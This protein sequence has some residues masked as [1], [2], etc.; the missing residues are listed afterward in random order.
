NGD[1]LITMMRVARP[2]VDVAPT[3]LPDP[4]EPRLLVEAN[5]VKGQRPTFAVMIEGVDDD[6][7][8]RVGEDGPGFVDLDRNFMHEW[9]EHA[10]DAGPYQLCEP[11]SLALARFVLERP[12]IVAAVVYGR[13]DN[14]INV[15]SGKGEDV[16]GR[17]PKALDAGDV[18]LYKEMSSLFKDITGQQRA[19]KA[20]HDGSLHAWLYAQRGIPTFATVVW[21]RPD[22]PKPEEGEKGEG[23]QAGEGAEGEKPEPPGGG[24]KKAKAEDKPAD[25]EAAA[26]LEWLDAV[27]DGAGFVGWTPVDH[28]TLGGV[29]V[30]GFVP[31]VRMNPPAAELDALAGKQAAFAVALLERRPRLTVGAPTVR[32]LGPGLYEVHLVIANEGYLPTATAMARRARTVMP[33]VVRLSVPLEDVVAGERVSRHWGID[34]SGRRV[35]QHWIVRVR[36]GAPVEVE[37]VN[38]QLGDMTVRFSAR[39]SSGEEGTP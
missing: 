2:P 37:I 38:P 39:P 5:A 1:G 11:E 7:D 10:L 32:R 26:W 13:H 24:P 30:G 27:R 14:L 18:P 20:D 33:T 9:P 8:G 29:E 35:V 6:G 4:V 31:G 22:L 12:N 36:D 3:H 16:S 34:G 25:E 19:A 21:G 15:P 28:P 17:G 23:E